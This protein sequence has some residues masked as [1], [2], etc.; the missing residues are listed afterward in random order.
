M[1]V[2]PAPAPDGSI[3]ATYALNLGLSPR[4][5]AT[6]IHRL[7]R[8]GRATRYVAGA[9][10]PERGS[11][12]YHS[13]LGLAAPSACAPAVLPDGRI[14]L[15]YDPGA[16]GDY[17]LW[18]ASADDATLAPLLDLP[19]TL[20]LD[21]AAVVPR[22]APGAWDSDPGIAAAAEPALV[23]GDLSDK[24]LGTFAF[25]C[26]DVFASGGLAG[27]PARTRGLVLRFYAALPRFDRAGGDTAVL[28]RTVPVDARGAIR[29]SGLPAGVPMFEQ[30]AS[31]D[32]MPLVTA[33][34]PA[35][36]AG[37]NAGTAGAVTRCVGCHTGHSRL[38]VS[39][40]RPVPNPR[41]SAPPRH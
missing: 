41:G 39:P 10:V 20:E 32:G 24:A 4:P 8:R 14:V 30:L 5:G 1:G 21:A 17:G 38:P 9:I 40:V 31:A 29:A 34:G 36:V 7:D 22:P 37:L 3:V 19:G 23:R 25:E 27:A 28:L 13:A 18:V 2:E 35:H 16:R 12:P 26:A 11:D 15:S 33:H 6:G